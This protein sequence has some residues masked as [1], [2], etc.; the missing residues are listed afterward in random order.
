MILN[1]YRTE[2]DRVILTI[3]IGFTDM[4]RRIKE[5]SSHL[6][7]RMR[8]KEGASLFEEYVLDEGYETKFRSYFYSVQ[9]EL[10]K[11][12]SA[13]TKDVP[14]SSLYLDTSATS[15]GL[16]ADWT[17][18]LPMPSNF[19]EAVSQS[20]G[21]KMEDFFEN[22]IMFLWLST[23]DTSRAETYLTLSRKLAEEIRNLLNR[24]SE[25]ITRPNCYW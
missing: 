3:V 22:Y 14:V 4:Q 15:A 10:S 11:Y 8:D 17:V 16:P 24:R 6:A 18:I 21:L 23:K 9:G 2:N 25:N 13:Y 1:I 19:N 20:I 5:E 12:L 7:I